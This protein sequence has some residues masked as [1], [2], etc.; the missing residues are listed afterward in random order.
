V[1]EDLLRMTP[2]LASQYLMSQRHDA[3]Y[4]ISRRKFW[5]PTTSKSA[6]KDHAR[7]RNTGI[8]I[9]DKRF[10][11]AASMKGNRYL[12]KVPLSGKSNDVPH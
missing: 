5:V 6:G 8:E 3:R 1:L 4:G 2:Q 9:C 7:T 10:K 11:K 12:I